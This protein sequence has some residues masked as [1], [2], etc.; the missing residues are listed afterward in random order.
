M[1]TEVATPSKTVSQPIDFA[2]RQRSMDIALKSSLCWAVMFGVGE[3]YFSIFATYI[4][5]PRFYFGL[6]AGIPSLLGPISQLFGADA[7][8][9]TGQRKRLTQISVCMQSLCYAPLAVL[10]F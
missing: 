8:D 5:A 10:P 7:V 3:C 1:S 4:H 9:H 2:L 6:M